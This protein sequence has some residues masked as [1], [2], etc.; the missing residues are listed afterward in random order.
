MIFFLLSFSKQWRAEGNLPRTG[1]RQMP[2]DFK[3]AQTERENQHCLESPTD[4]LLWS[5]EGMFVCCVHIIT[6]DK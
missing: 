4:L 3:R 6:G 1:C 5:P 2:H